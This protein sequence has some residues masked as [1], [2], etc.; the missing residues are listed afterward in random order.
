MRRRTRTY[1]PRRR[2]IRRRPLRRARRMP[3][4]KSIK[5]KSYLFK[6]SF[7]AANLS[8]ASGAALNATFQFRLADLPA[9]TD[10]TNLFQ[11]YK[12]NR[13]KIEFTPD[14]NVGQQ[15]SANGMFLIYGVID[16]ETLTTLATTAQ[17][18]EYNSLKIWRCN[19][20]HK[21]YLQPSG[22]MGVNDVASTAYNI[23]SK[24]QWISSSVNTVEHL[25]YKLISDT[26]AT[27]NTYTCYVRLTYYISV[28]DVF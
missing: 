6:R 10:F 7:T 1:R 17:A 12:I 9:V 24:P 21:V 27:G 3:M 18:E 22:T 4:L 14:F 26:N 16:R 8:C 19:E 11:R 25:G 20:K 28:K 23:V 15:I 2:I 13:V 5:P